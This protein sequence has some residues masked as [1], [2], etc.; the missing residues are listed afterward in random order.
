MDK[1]PIGIFDS[2]VG[3]LTVLRQVEKLL[4]KEDIIYFGD[5]ARVPYGN[6]SRDT[7]IKFTTQSILF[8]LRKKVKMIIIACNTSSSLAL[9]S[10]KIAFSL[11]I[12]GVIE[13]GVRKALESST[14]NKIAVIGTKSTILSRSYQKE[15]RK[16]NKNVKVY[17][18]SCPL[19]VPLAEEGLLRGKIVEATIKMYLKKIKDKKP[20]A[21]ILGC[22]HYPLLKK[23]IADYLAGVDIIDSAQQV[24]L[25]AKALL[26]NK[27]LLS[28]RGGNKEFYVSDEPA[29]FIKLAKLFLKR[30]ISGPK[31]VNV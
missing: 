27:S 22:T 2:G 3:G 25:Q 13:S 26:Q 16:V 7:I 24:A 30:E 12:I 11:P 8:L 9:D 10:L 23:P 18:Q 19:F 31:V 20:G 15:I 1:R 14:N 21:V 5:T 28:Q 29:G 17:V 4:P 6:K